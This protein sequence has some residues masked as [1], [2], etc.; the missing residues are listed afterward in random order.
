MIPP[1]WSESTRSPGEIELFDVLRDAPGT[2][3]WVVLHSLD[4]SDHVARTAGEVD[5]V[6]IIPGLGVVALEVKAHQRVRR[7]RGVWFLGSDAEG[8]PRGP[9]KQASQACHSLRERAKKDV[10]SAGGV[11]FF[12]A[13]CFPYVSFSDTSPE[14]HPWQVID[15]AALS[16]RPLPDLL[17]G[18]LRSGREHLASSSNWFH[19]DTEEPTPETVD[20]IVRA[21]RGDFEVHETPKARR[22]RLDAEVLHYTQDQI[23]ALDQVEDNPRVLFDGPAGTGK[24]V[25]AIESARRAA[26]RGHRVL[27][28]CFNR[29]L[30]RR[31]ASETEGLP[32]VTAGTIDSH[33]VD[34]SK[35]SPPD[36]AGSDYWRREL[37]DRAL[38]KLLERDRPAFDLVI[39]DEAQ[40]L[41]RDTYL[42]VLE[43]ELEGG[44]ADGRW[45]AFGDLSNQAIYDGD[46]PFDE[47]VR[48]R[49]VSFRFALTT[50]CR[51]TPRVAAY[52]QL[53]GDLDRGYV[54][55][56]R[57]D[58]G[59]EPRTRVVAA[60][61]SPGGILVRVLDELVSDGYRPEDIVVL[62][63]VRDGAARRVDTPRWS[64]RLLPFDDPRSGAARYGT[65]H[66]FKG[67]ESPV[68]VVTDVD[69][70]DQRHERRLLYVAVTRALQRVVVLVD[71]PGA[72]DLATIFAGS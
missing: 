60:D 14:W 3:D 25:L 1:I 62:S 61:E 23:R 21:L 47:L 8:D 19:P 20:A 58:D 70:L 50:N 6:V 13:V 17:V 63:T 37:P 4:L 26:L 52:A 39:M 35:T 5:F 38:E 57:P 69:S 43:L 59:S 11:P 45:L 64:G 22:R 72:R 66:E 18:V 15:L 53:L 44:L 30:G 33:L 56:L 31:L 28:V 24:T 9:F 49:G 12:S 68:V 55:T 48:R 54:R 71:G 7:S 36:G 40:D 10:A 65:I 51:N 34:V 32:L 67:L 46:A 29:Q 42:D 41:A 16:S 2:E 27:L